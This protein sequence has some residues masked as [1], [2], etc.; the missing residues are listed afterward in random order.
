MSILQRA[1]LVL[2][3]ASAPTAAMAV[4]A[5]PANAVCKACDEV[6]FPTHTHVCKNISGDGYTTCTAFW[7]GCQMSGFCV[8]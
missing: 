5:Q 6:H 4:Q 2:A 8:G 7:W 1:A 3:L